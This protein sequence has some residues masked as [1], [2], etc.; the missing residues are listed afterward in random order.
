MSR[1]GNRTNASGVMPVQHADFL[2]KTD[3]LRGFIDL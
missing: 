1:G 2:L 3:Y